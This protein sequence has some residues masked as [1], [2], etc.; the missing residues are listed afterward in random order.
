MAQNMA[1]PAQWIKGKS[2]QGRFVIR[3]GRP[4]FWRDGQ[5]GGGAYCLQ[6]KRLET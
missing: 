6:A 3:A 5:T 2:Q 1:I 4:V